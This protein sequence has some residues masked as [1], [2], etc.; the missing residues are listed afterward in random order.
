MHPIPTPHHHPLRQKSCY[1][2]TRIGW[3]WYRRENAREE[4]ASEC[5]QE[6]SSRRCHCRQQPSRRLHPIPTMYSF[7]KLFGCPHHRY[8][9]SHHE[10]TQQRASHRPQYEQIQFCALINS[11]WY[12]ALHVNCCVWISKPKLARRSLTTNKHIGLSC[13]Y[14]ADDFF[15]G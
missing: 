5:T 1:L 6:D 13:G 14:M 15:R 11:G 9:S 10:P 8:R 3:R 7:P 4:L 2:R 12:G